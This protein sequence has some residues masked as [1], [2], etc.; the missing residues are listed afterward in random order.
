MTQGYLGLVCENTTELEQREPTECAAKSSF[1][2]TGR[3]LH[4][5]MPRSLSRSVK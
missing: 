1:P 3:L 2:L 5:S 4:I